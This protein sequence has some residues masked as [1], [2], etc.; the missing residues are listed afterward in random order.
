MLLLLNFIQE[1]ELNGIVNW[2]TEDSL[3]TIPV[4]SS[5]LFS[6]TATLRAFFPNIQK[7]ALLGAVFVCCLVIALYV[8]H[9]N[10]KNENFLLVVINTLV[11]FTSTIGTNEILTEAVSNTTAADVI[12]GTD[13]ERSVS[14]TEKTIFS[15]QK[16][17]KRQFFKSWLK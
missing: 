17:P 15:E 5:V 13:N 14:Q 8:V 10:N 2:I 3:K 11:L 7:K 9:E 1:S 12:D 6:L 4:A 16:S